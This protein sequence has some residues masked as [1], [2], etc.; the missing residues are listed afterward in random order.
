MEHGKAGK[1]V[2]VMAKEHR[3]GSGVAKGTLMFVAWFA[4][5]FCLHVCCFLH[6]PKPFFFSYFFCFPLLSF[7]TWFT[8]VSLNLPLRAMMLWETVY[9]R[10]WR[11]GY[12]GKKSMMKVYIRNY[13]VVMNILGR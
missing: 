9:P 10:I 6:T 2:A 3:D 8:N 4:C 13:E 12:E 1:V 7:L 11:L 5:C